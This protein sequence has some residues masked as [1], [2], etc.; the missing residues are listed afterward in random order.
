MQ[1]AYFFCYYIYPV[2]F[3]FIVFQTHKLGLLS[4]CLVPLSVAA[5]LSPCLW[6]WSCPLGPTAFAGLGWSICL[7]SDYLPFQV[8]VCCMNLGLQLPM[9]CLTPSAPSTKNL[10]SSLARNL[11]P[12]P[13]SHSISSSW[14]S[15]QVLSQRVWWLLKG[16][17][18]TFW[19]V[20][21][22]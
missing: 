3:T 22:S 5:Q 1:T 20:L 10:A 15:A 12:S 14:A 8:T 6:L 11:H 21:M 9:D 2:P 19:S 7:P 17:R 13:V 16:L 18:V 4:S